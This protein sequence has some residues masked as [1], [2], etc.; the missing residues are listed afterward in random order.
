MAKQ[1]NSMKTVAG[2]G[3][4]MKVPTKTKTAKNIDK[5]AKKIEKKVATEEKETTKRLS[6]D[7]PEKLYKAMKMKVLVDGL[8]VRKYVLDLIENDLV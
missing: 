1:R 2:L 8:T 4:K 7:I 6:I 5:I 3:S